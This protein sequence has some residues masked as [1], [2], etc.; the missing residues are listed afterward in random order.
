MVATNDVAK[1]L[2]IQSTAMDLARLTGTDLET[3]TKAL[4][5][6]KADCVAYESPLLQFRWDEVAGPAK[7]RFVA[8]GYFVAGVVRPEGLCLVTQA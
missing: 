5:A 4:I 8:A 3:A 2:D 6:R 1:S 7:I